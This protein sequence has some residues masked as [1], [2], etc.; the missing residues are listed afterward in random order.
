VDLKYGISD[1]DQ[2]L[3]TMEYVWM[4][5]FCGLP[6]ISVPAGFV[7]PEGAKGAG[8]VA[9]EGTEG[10]VPVGFMGMGEWA[11]EEELLWF[12][13]DCEE[14]GQEGSS[15]PPIWVDVVELAKEEMKRTG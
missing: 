13:A 7:V 3:K 2:T 4:G 14:I 10:K 1:G 9:E 5:N 15:R 12:G 8:E 11:T 6:S